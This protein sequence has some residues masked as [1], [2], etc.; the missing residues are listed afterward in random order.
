MGEEKKEEE[1]KKAAAEAAAAKLKAE[2]EKKKGV[3]GWIQDNKKLAGGIAAGTLAA[4]AIGYKMMGSKSSGSVLSSNSCSMNNPMACI[5]QA[6]ENPV[7]V[8]GGVAALG[9]AFL[10][11]TK[12]GRNMAH[13]AWKAIRCKS[14][15]KDSGEKSNSNTTSEKED[16]VDNAKLNENKTDNNKKTKKKLVEKVNE[17]CGVEKKHLENFNKYKALEKDWGY[18]NM[19]RIFFGGDFKG[20]TIKEHL[21][22]SD[23]DKN[24]PHKVWKDFINSK[25]FKAALSNPDHKARVKE[26]LKDE[27]FDKKEKKEKEK[28]Y[29]EMLLVRDTIKIVDTLKKIGDNID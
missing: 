9:A 26:A 14:S 11:L 25:Y 19:N 13:S 29:S 7:A 15:G 4:G 3:L 24:C 27:D 16:S 10:T 6:S 18:H 23:D 22:T 1:D 2:K 5:S 8:A 17:H 20:V 12:T 21:F 28:K